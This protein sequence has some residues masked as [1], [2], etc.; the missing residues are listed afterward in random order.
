MNKKFLKTVQILVVLSLIFAVGC[1]KNKD[2]DKNNDDVGNGTASNPFKVATV[3][4]LKRVASDEVGPGGFVW[5]NGMHYEQIANID[6]SS[7]ANW[8]PICPSVEGTLSPPFNGTYDGGGYTI[9]NL[10]ILEDAGNR[11]GLFAQLTGTVSNLRLNKVNITGKNDVGSIAGSMGSGGKVYRCSVNDLFITGYDWVGGVTGDAGVGATVS[12]CMVT[13][14]TVVSTNFWC[15]GVVGYNSGMIENCYTTVTLEGYYPTGGIAAD[16]SGN[17]MV[18]YCY[19]T[20]NVTSDRLHVGGI[21]KNK[22]KI[23]NCVALNKEVKKLGGDND[24]IGR[25]TGENSNQGELLNNYARP[26]MTLMSGT[27]IVP[28][29]DATTTSI[30]GANV[31]AADYNGANSDTWWSNTAGFPSSE[32]SFAPNRLPHLKGF[33]GLTQNPTVMP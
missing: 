17:G 1:E 12:S 19:A 5:S 3:A 29:T 31:S 16:N 8:K 18:R 22:G 11:I 21:A 26:D 15:G 14:G 13:N 23:Q 2:D 30:H 25:V 6:L 32:W 27:N 20:G 33:D 24:G 7:E 4:D 10:T 9:S 28:V